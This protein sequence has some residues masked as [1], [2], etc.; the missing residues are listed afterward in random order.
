MA[1]RKAGA[2][3]PALRQCDTKAPP[4]LC[5]IGINLLRVV[6]GRG[7]GRYTISEETT[8]TT[9]PVIL[10]PLIRKTSAGWERLVVGTA[11]KGSP[12]YEPV[13][14]DER[15]W[16][17]RQEQARRARARAVQAEMG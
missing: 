2:H 17:I 9:Q 4:L 1:Y 5:H 13:E 8:M 6:C 7:V 14:W 3:L 10:L 15:A 11:A 16:E 12:R